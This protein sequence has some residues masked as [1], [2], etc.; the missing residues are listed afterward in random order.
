MVLSTNNLTLK[1]F[2]K[3]PETDLNHELIDGQAIPKMSPKFFHSRIQKTLLLLLDSCCKNY[4]RIEPEWAVCLT[5]NGK[6]WVPIPD[7]T[8]ISYQRLAPDW[9]LDEPCPVAPALVIEIISPGQSFGDLAEKATN[10]LI[11]GVLRVWIIDTQAQSIT[12][13]Y[14]DTLPQTIRLLSEVRGKGKGEGLKGKELI[15]TVS[16]KSFREKSI[17][18][19]TIITDD[20]LP[21]MQL[22]PQQIFQFIKGTGNGEQGTVKKN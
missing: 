10:Y 13:F 8:Y 20:I 9:M 3:L 19:N 11:A 2:L 18:G 16:K 21:E 12:I 17:R 4:G 7:L 5:K 15:T 14:P 1:D 6:D 22:T